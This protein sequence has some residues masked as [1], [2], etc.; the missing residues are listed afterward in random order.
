MTRAAVASHLW[1]PPAQ[2]DA[3]T[4]LAQDQPT[5]GHEVHVWSCWSSA[6][7]NHFMLASMTYAMT[8]PLQGI[9]TSQPTAVKD[10][11]TAMAAASSGMP[12]STYRAEKQLAKE[13]SLCLLLCSCPDQEQTH[14][15]TCAGTVFD[16]DVPREEGRDSTNSV[17][18][19]LEPC[20]S[21]SS[22]LKGWSSCPFAY[23]I[24]DCQD[25]LQLWQACHITTLHSNT[26]RKTFNTKKRIF[27]FCKATSSNHCPG[28]AVTV[29]DT[30]G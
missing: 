30:A 5:P 18:G 9:W 16:T 4:A 11:P 2:Q 28:P 24:R 6:L 20:C 10:L 3:H 25:D 8:N 27:S 22:W 26:V 14:T 29:P 7:I 17:T 12:S 1:L 15:H 23:L 19:L 13:V 21:N